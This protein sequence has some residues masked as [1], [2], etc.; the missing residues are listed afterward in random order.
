MIE[1]IIPAYNCMS[2]LGRTL[3][4]L[5]KQSNKDFTVLLIDDCSSQDIFSIVERY[6]GCLN[7]KYI[8]NETNRGVGMTR[9]RGIDE[10]NAEYIAFLDSDDILLSNAVDDWNK[11]ININNPDAIYSPFIYVWSTGYKVADSFWMCHGKVYN[12]SFLKQYDIGESE[13]VVCID[14]GYLN[15]QVFDLAKNVSMLTIPT[16]IQIDTKNSVTNTMKFKQN[17]HEDVKRAKKLAVKQIS[18]FKDKPLYNYEKLYQDARKMVFM[19]NKDN[20]ELIQR[21]TYKS[22]PKI[23]FNSFL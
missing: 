1:I 17:L 14:D 4:S 9:Q 15:W 2:T 6:K 16:Y 21:V 12:T 18:Q 13:Q 20:K 23:T 3:D 5:K 8:R 7:I 11:D 19:L 22:L 10:T